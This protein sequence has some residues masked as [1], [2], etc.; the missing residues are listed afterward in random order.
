MKRK[1]LFTVSVLAACAMSSFLG[2]CAPQSNNNEEQDLTPSEGLEFTLLDD[3]ES[4]AFTGLGTCTDK[5]L[6]IPATYEGKP[7]TQVGRYLT[8]ADMI[9][10][11]PEI[12][13]DDNAWY[14][15]HLL[16]CDMLYLSDVR[17]V[18]VPDGVTSI[19]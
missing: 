18:Y 14:S 4:Y 19:G 12:E 1:L 17:S 7:V 15:A 3:G 11:T 10:A 2:S 13:E 9:A 5:D 8:A 6:V 16:Y